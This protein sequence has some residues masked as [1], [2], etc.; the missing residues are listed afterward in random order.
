MGTQSPGTVRKTKCLLS[1]ALMRL[2]QRRSFRKISVGDICQEAMVSR[3]AFYMHF[4]DK[5]E[6]LRFAL[7]DVIRMQDEQNRGASFEKRMMFWLESVQENRQMI[8]HM[9]LADLSQ[10][11]MDIFTETFEMAV[12][13]WILEMQKRGVTLTES[14]ELMTAFYAGGL[15]NVLM[16][17]IRE[18]FKTSKEEIARCQCRMMMKLMRN[19]GGA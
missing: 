14:V 1:G 8:H 3:S 2:L 16:M 15:A 13:E 4:P 7:Q 6:L 10:E 19:E 12:R 11:M 18:N 9:F 17:W 5:Y